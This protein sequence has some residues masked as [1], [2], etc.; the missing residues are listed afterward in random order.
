MKTRKLALLLSLT[1][2]FSILSP[3]MAFAAS[4]DLDTP[5]D[6]PVEPEPYAHID[7]IGIDFCV[8]QGGSSD[9][10]CSAYIADRNYHYTLTLRLQQKVNGVWD[11]TNPIK[12]W[13]NSGSGTVYID[14]SYSGLSYGYYRLSAT[15]DVY[16]SSNLLCESVTEY[17][18]VAY[19]SSAGVFYY[20]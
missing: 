19:Y 18:R 17:S 5:V 13:S 12:T 4:S 11:T 6:D 14:E 9:D 16:N 8:Y 2:L 15:V 7:D 10:Y 3:V 1:M 20:L